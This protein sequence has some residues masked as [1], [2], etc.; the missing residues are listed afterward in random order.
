MVGQFFKLPKEAVEQ[1]SRA[2]REIWCFAVLRIGHC[3]R[4]CRRIHSHGG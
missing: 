1:I 4:A 3:G 2:S